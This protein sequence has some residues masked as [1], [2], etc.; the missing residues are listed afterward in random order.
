MVALNFAFVQLWLGPE[1]FAGQRVTL[2]LAC[3]V[4]F[5]VTISS[6]GEVIFAVGG[7]GKIEVLRATEGVVRILLQYLLLIRFGLVGIPLGGCLSLAVVS[8]WYLPRLWS[9]QVGGSASHAYLQ[10]AVHIL[11]AGVLLLF[12]MAAHVGFSRFVSHWTWPRLAASGIAVAVA[13]ILIGVAMNSSIRREL[14]LLGERAR[15]RSGRSG[16]G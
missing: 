16:G 2:A 4:A 8:C 11:R 14:E 9:R 15:A 5:N 10:L 3:F 13:A 12:G 1:L 6:L 7:V